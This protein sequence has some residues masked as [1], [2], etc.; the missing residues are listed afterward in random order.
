MVRQWAD[1]DTEPGVKEAVIHSVEEPHSGW[2]AI[3]FAWLVT[4][5]GDKW[6]ISSACVLIH[7]RGSRSL[8][9]KSSLGN[10]DGSSTLLLLPRWGRNA[11]ALISFTC[12]LSGGDAPYKNAA[13]CVR[14][15]ED[16]MKARSI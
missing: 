8:S 13:T 2:S 7:P 9:R 3:N 12:L 16:D 5:V 10:C 11:I 6:L 14:R 1:N 4:S 15:S